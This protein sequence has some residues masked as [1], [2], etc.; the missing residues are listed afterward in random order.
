MT[1]NTP[2]RARPHL[3][4]LDWGTT[5]LRAW[6]L[7]AGGEVIAGRRRTRGLLSMSRLST[8]ERA[9]EYER[10]F[11]E[12]CGD[13]HRDWPGLPSLACGMVGSAGGWRDAGY[14]NVPTDLAIGASDLIEVPHPGGVLHLVPGLRIPSRDDSPGD[15]LRG[16]ECQLIGALDLMG[17][18]PSTLVFILPGTHTKWVRVEDRQ[19]LSF[20]TAMTGELFGLLIHHGLL[21]RTSELGTRDDDAFARGLAA[22][23]RGLPTELFGGR[24]LVLDGLL[25]AAA[26]P[27]YL[28]GVLIGDEIRHQ[29]PPHDAADH[30]VLC[31]E[32]DL[33][34]RY[35][36]ALARAGV[37]PRVVTGDASARGLWSIAHRAG[38][39]TSTN[40]D[41]HGGS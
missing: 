14:R 9:A 39:V 25:D 30:F 12:V 33:C 15:V 34:R 21:A 19:V 40:D 7:G 10:V 2:G 32:P 38:L 3:V 24:A 4:A 41:E 5:S 29:L 27:D 18:E 23:D 35:E 13:W 17:L 36:S 22:A 6:L 16:E 8:D 28:S 31:G 26:L 1:P 11:G 20:A 37:A